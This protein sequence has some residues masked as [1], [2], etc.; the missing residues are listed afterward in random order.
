MVAHA[1]AQLNADRLGATISR[2]LTQTLFIHVSHNRLSWHCSA[3]AEPRCYEN[4]RKPGPQGQATAR[5]VSDK[6]GPKRPVISEP[7][8]GRCALTS[9]DCPP[10]TPIHDLCTFEDTTTS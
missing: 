8:G 2:V 9:M 6:Y 4:D 10:L 1:V 5:I 7:V 3:S